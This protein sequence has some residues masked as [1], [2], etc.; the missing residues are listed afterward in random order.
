MY[1]RSF[2]FAQYA[3]SA[4]TTSKTASKV[5]VFGVFVVRIFQHSDSK[6]RDTKYLSVFSPNA[7]KC[8]RKKE[9]ERTEP[10]RILSVIHSNFKNQVK[11]PN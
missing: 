1:S 8:V 4:N 11:R 10:G 7:G 6:Q 2:V 3:S 9:Q 5:S